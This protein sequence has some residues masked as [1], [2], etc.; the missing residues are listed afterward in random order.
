MGR[1]KRRVEAKKEF[2]LFM[3]KHGDD[4]YE[5]FDILSKILN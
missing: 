4:F 2:A 3:M 5:A 1:L